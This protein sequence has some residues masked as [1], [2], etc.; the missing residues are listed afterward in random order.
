MS[1]H[2]QSSSFSKQPFKRPP[3]AAK[4]VRMER[5][6]S[7]TLNGETQLLFGSVGQP[8]PTS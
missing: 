4:V 1:A 2:G 8:V 5:L 3:G 6:F 7:S